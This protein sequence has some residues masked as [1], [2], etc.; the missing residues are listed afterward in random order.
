MPR[1]YFYLL[2]GW[3]HRD[4]TGQELSG[5][6][7]VCTEIKQTLADLVQQ[8]SGSLSA[9]VHVRDDT[10]QTVVTAS[11]SLAFQAPDTHH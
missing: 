1:Y 3:L 6:P 2:D 8:T 10:N 5:M 11:I 9:V 4:E 7:Q